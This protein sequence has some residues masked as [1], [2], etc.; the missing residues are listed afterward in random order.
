PLTDYPPFSTGCGR[1]PSPYDHEIGPAVLRPDGTVFATG[2]NLCGAGNTAIYDTH[3]SV[4]DTGKWKAG[5]PIPNGYD[6]ADGP[7]SIL[8]DGN[9]LV[10]TSPAYGAGPSLFWEFGLDGSWIAINQPA[11]LPASASTV[12]ARMLVTGSGSVMLL[13]TDSE[14]IWI[15]TKRGGWSYPDSWRPTICGG[16]YPKDVYIGQVNYAVDGTQFNGLSQGA[17]YGD[18]AQSASN[19]PLVLFTNN[20]SG[21]KFYARTHDHSTMGVATGDELV[22]TLFDIT[23]NIEPG[24]STMVVIANGIPSLPVN[25]RVHPA[26]GN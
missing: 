6:V 14:D 22:G 5:P 16:C 13:L 26:P 19:Y 20:A 1:K 18:D 12:H 9:V 23:P 4:T 10:D 8:P 24:P 15:Y 2:A 3:G 7:A 11:D 25:I 21:H 17:A